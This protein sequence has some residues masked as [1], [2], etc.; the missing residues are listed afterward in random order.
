MAAVAHQVQLPFY[1]HKLKDMTPLI[2][3]LAINRQRDMSG[4]SVQAVYW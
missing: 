2:G 4:R 1:I 3:D